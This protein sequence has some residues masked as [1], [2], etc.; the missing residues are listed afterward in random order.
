MNVKT[1]CLFISLDF[2][3]SLEAIKSAHTTS[4]N[5]RGNIFRGS[6]I[7]NYMSSIDPIINFQRMILESISCG[8]NSIKIYILALNLQKFRLFP[9]PRF[10]T[11]KLKILTFP[12]YIQLYLTFLSIKKHK[13]LLLLVHLIMFR[14]FNFPNILFS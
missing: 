12:L 9:S 1:L 7:M 5:S 3:L 14:N 4:H 2:C 13:Y 6:K 11:Y 8:A 10:G